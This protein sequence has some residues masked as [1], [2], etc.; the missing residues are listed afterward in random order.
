MDTPWQLVP[1]CP[2]DTQASRAT[3]LCTEGV[4]LMPLI[5]DPA[6]PWPRAAFSQF[7]RSRECCDCATP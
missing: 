2:A 6:S 1:H 5:R 4:S 7:V 3:A